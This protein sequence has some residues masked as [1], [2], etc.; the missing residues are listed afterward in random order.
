MLKFAK[1]REV[2]TPEQAYPGVDACIDF[3]IPKFNRSFILEYTKINKFYTELNINEQLYTQLKQDFDLGSKINNTTMLID[4]TCN[5]IKIYGK[6]RVLI[7]SGIK[8]NIPKHT[9]FIGYNRS[10]VAYNKGLIVGACVVDHGYQGQIYISLINTSDKEVY[11]N[12][13]QKIIQ[14]AHIPVINETIK[15]VDIEQLYDNISSRSDGGF[16]STN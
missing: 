15:Q 12:Q 3:F 13:N 16:G 1:I 10:S 9:A 7:P 2:K 4:P 6:S 8:I 5:N 14:F 11:I